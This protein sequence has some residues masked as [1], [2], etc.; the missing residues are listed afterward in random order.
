MQEDFGTNANTRCI[1]CSAAQA[2]LGYANNQY[3]YDCF[4]RRLEAL[5]PGWRAEIVFTKS[6]YDDVP[7]GVKVAPDL[8][9][10]TEGGTHEK[11]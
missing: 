10:V 2:V 6:G 7:D 1:C 9:E 4:E 5:Q 8:S 3:C 11:R